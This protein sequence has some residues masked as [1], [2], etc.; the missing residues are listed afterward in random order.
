MIVDAD[1]LYVSE[2]TVFRILK[3]E[4]LIKPADVV[5]FKAG[6]KYHRKT[7]RPN[8]LWATDCAQL[9]VIDWGWYY[10]VTVMDDFSR[11]I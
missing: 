1:G 3:R 11:F 10:L 6:R 5:G 2:S 7:K 4:G 9:Q 8:E